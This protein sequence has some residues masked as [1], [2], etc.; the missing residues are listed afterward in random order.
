M[1]YILWRR[2]LLKTVASRQAK[3]P[4]RWPLLLPSAT[5]MA[6]AIC[7]QCAFYGSQVAEVAVFVT[8]KFLQNLNFRKF[9]PQEFWGRY[10][11]NYKTLRLYLTINSWGIA[12]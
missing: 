12:W 7:W 6:F 10:A 1:S 11:Q 8:K 3:P 2:L 9:L 5:R 4:F